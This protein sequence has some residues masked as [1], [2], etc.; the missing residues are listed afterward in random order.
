M[1]LSI[2]AQ[3]LSL[4]LALA[5]GAGLGL[6]YDLLRPIR[7]HGGGSIWDALFCLCAAAAAFLFAMRAPDGVL[8]S[9]E[10]LLSLFGLLLYFQLLSPV[11]LPIFDKLDRVIGAIWIITQNARKKVLLFAKKLFQNSRE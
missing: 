10:V 9:S 8:G 5:L 1:E 11:F 6:L 2:R 7:R 4:G 3:A